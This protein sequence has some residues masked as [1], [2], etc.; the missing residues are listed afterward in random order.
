[1]QVID[2]FKDLGIPVPPGPSAAYYRL[3]YNP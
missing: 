2:S 3:R 1:M